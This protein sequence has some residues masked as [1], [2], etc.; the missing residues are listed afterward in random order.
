MSKRKLSS[1]EHVTVCLRGIAK[2][3]RPTWKGED[4]IDAG[5]ASYVEI[6]VQFEPQAVAYVCDQWKTHKR[7]W[8][9]ISDLVGLIQS[10]TKQEQEDR[11]VPIDGGIFRNEAICLLGRYYVQAKD[12]LIDD[13]EQRSF[14]AEAA[15][16]WG[17]VRPAGGLDEVDKTRGAR[18]VYG[19]A[20][21]AWARYR[22]G[23][24][25]IHV[26]YI[27]PAIVEVHGRMTD[28]DLL[29]RGELPDMTDK[30][31]AALYRPPL[32]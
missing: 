2:V 18:A 4:E 25:E 1:P 26:A 23:D 15:R 30:P 14:I 5:I 32:I 29:T 3:L 8:P 28:S 6:L 11:P 10:T 12:L 16:L 7:R 9:F 19:T 22:I 31:R 21:E 27:T 13:A 20:L 17:K 24:E